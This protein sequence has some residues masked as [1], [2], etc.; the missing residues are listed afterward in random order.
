MEQW[1]RSGLTA[2]EFAAS[3]GVNAN[4]LAYW[5]WHLSSSTTD[6]STAANAGRCV[7]SFVEIV[8]PRTDAAD[9]SSAKPLEVVL[10]GNLVVRVPPEFDAAL[11]RRV[12]DAL[13]GRS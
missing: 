10:P 5:K 4:T 7:P 12:V 9:I 1:L 13:G 3:E 2:K 11:L 8:A 6:A